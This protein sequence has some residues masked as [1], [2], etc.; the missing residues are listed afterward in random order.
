MRSLLT[1]CL[2]EMDLRVLDACG[3]LWEQEGIADSRG[4][5]HGW[6]GRRRS[7]KRGPCHHGWW[8]Q[9]RQCAR[10]PERGQR[11]ARED[12]FRCRR[13]AGGLD[14]STGVPVAQAAAKYANDYLGGIGRHPIR[15]DVRDDKQT[16]SDT[17]DCINQF[18]A[19]KVPIVLN[20]VL[21]SAIS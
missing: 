10:Y 6:A 21:S 13:Q 19:D 2:M 14:N 7:D 16:P 5:Q 18:I 20:N 9:R 12:W 1:T 8:R 3:K 4:E 15:L 17:T 11:P